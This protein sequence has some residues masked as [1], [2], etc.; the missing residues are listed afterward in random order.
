MDFF[1]S[2]LAWHCLKPTKESLILQNHKLRELNQQLKTE[3]ANTISMITA[4]EQ[5][6]QQQRQQVRHTRCTVLS[7]FFFFFFCIL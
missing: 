6:A 1:F 3:V 7:S 2:R 4:L 5:A